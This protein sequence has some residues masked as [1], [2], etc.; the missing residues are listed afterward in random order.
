VHQSSRALF[1][2]PGFALGHRAAVAALQQM[3]CNKLWSAIQL[4]PASRHEWLVNREHCGRSI[5]VRRS[6]I[7]QGS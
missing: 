2:C 3:L 7:I 1:S 4:S 5:S 6:A